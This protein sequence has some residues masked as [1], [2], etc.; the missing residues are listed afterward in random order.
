MRLVALTAAL[1]AASAARA[2]ADWFASLY[3]GDGI[4]LRADER[5]FTLYALLNA[6][7]YDEAPVSRS[8]P[9]PKRVFHPVRQQVRQRLAASDPEVRKLADTF[10][11]AHP[12]PLQRYLAFAVSV[13]P[14]PFSAAPRSK[15]HADLKGL[16]ALLAKAYSGWKLEELLASVQ[17]E[18]RRGLKGYLA[19][20]D[21]PMGRA[22]R[23]LRA[24]EGGP[25]STL[26]MNLLDAKDA[27]RAAMGEGA[28]VIVVG[29]SEKPNLEGV[30]REYAAVLLE[31]QLAR[32]AQ[33]GW[34]GGAALLKEAQLLGAH[35]QGVGEYAVSLFARAVALRALEAPEAAYEGAAKTGYFGLR[36]IARGFEEGRPLDSWAMDALAK[37][38]TRRPAPRK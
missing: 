28:V 36:E 32:R 6:M 1:L 21:G 31:P 14:P 17:A 4:E 7:G 34:A 35:E 3:T 8:H 19:A 18:Y 12:Q 27:V 11:D 26:V 9:I 29:P 15:E 30:L 20:L 23:L 16:E 33:S 2:E 10:F 38:E 24:Q 22:R 13:G 25:E 5:V 37:A